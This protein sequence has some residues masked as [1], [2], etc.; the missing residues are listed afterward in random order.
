MATR[1][2]SAG[3]EVKQ[4][5]ADSVDRGKFLLLV[6]I[7]ALIVAVYLAA[8]FHVFRVS[9][10]LCNAMYVYLVV[11]VNCASLALLLGI[12]L[13]AN[14]RG[15]NRQMDVMNAGTLWMFVAGN[16]MTG[17]INKLVRTLYASDWQCVAILVVYMS[18]VTSVPFLAGKYHM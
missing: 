13:L 17:V 12:H 16:L 14:S 1:S 2:N 5:D 6:L 11:A 18:V 8:D 3:Q 9:R 7:T 10:R 15:T 4:V